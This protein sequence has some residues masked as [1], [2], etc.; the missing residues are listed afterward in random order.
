MALRLYHTKPIGRSCS[1]FQDMLSGYNNDLGKMLKLNNKYILDVLLQFSTLNYIPNLSIYL[2]YN[3][4]NSLY[5]CSYIIVKKKS[6][7]S[8]WY[9]GHSCKERGLVI[10]LLPHFNSKNIHQLAV[11]LYYYSKSFIALTHN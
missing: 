3:T 8:I 7:F 11:H 4:L 10:K 6:L 1:N 2:H 5:I 9:T